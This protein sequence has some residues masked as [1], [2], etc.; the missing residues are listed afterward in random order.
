MNRL[1]NCIFEIAFLDRN[2]F[3]KSSARKCLLQ[4]HFNQNNFLIFTEEQKTKF[5]IIKKEALE[6]KD[7]CEKSSLMHRT[8]RQNIRFEIDDIIATMQHSCGIDDCVSKECY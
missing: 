3:V 5:E 7:Q 8:L 4:M 1:V 6:E 2:H